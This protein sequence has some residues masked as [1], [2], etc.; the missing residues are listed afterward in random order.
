MIEKEG[1]FSVVPH[2]SRMLLLSRIIS[3]DLE[4]RSIV[5]EYQITKDCIFYD[6][7]ADGVPAWVGFEFIAQSISA[8]SGI[9]DGE[10]GKS[11]KIGFVLAVSKLKMG[12]S[13]FKA[14][15]TITIKSREI[16]NMYPVY[17]FE[18]DIFLDGEK[19]LGG[20]LTVMEASDE[21][22]KRLSE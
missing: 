15:T 12:L 6:S 10:K 17:V 21:D 19:V 22:V 18:G 14:G 3:Y 1:L 8:F 13:F 4:E 20:K 16:D 5:A 9:R 7:V 2:R 11:P